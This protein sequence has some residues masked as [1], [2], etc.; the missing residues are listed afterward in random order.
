MSRALGVGGI[1]DHPKLGAA[2]DRVAEAVRKGGVAR[3]ALP[4][5][6]PTFPRNAA[7][8]RALGVGY[9]NCAPSPEVR[10][11]RSMQAQV[12]EARALLG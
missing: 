4:M 9:C 2:I 7:Q 12:A 1:P 10:M 8:L 11:L 3:L 6:H 5:N